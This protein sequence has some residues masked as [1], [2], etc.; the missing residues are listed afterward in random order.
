MGFQGLL[1]LLQRQVETVHPR[2]RRG[3]EERH[4][5]YSRIEIVESGLRFVQFRN[6]QLELAGFASL[7][8]FFDL[9]LRNQPGITHDQASSQRYNEKKIHCQPG[10][11]RNWPFQ[12]AGSVV[13]RND[14]GNH[15]Q[16]EGGLNDAFPGKRRQRD[17]HVTGDSENHQQSDNFGSRRFRLRE[18]AVSIIK[19]QPEDQQVAE[20]T[21]RP[22]LGKNPQ[23][24]IVRAHEVDF[25]TFRAQSFGTVTGQHNFPVSQPHPADGMIRD[26]LQRF[27]PQPQP[28]IDGGNREICPGQRFTHAFALH[29]AG[30]V[31][32]RGEQQRQ[33][34]KDGGVG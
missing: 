18:E 26:H 17:Q 19:N 15:Q 12:R 7:Q 23:K 9:N 13:E 14:H 21:D 30:K 22:G 24:V 16:Q 3:A 32:Q 28:L 6:F 34:K 4:R 33:G 1:K 10:A 20:E 31:R 27:L 8:G 11:G 5:G 25:P 2:L 29:G